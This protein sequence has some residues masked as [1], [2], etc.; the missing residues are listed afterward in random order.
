VETDLYSSVQQRKFVYLLLLTVADEFGNICQGR[1]ML[2]GRPLTH[3]TI[4]TLSETASEADR[5]NF[6]T[7]ATMMRKFD[8]VNVVYLHGIVNCVSSPHLLVMER[9]KYGPLLYF[10][11]VRMISTKLDKLSAADHHHHHHHHHHHRCRHH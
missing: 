1:L 3:V 7:K 5:L 6:L 10:I 2:T 9:M 4:E 8:D 11:R